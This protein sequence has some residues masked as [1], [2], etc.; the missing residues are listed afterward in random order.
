MIPLIKLTLRNPLIAWQQ[1]RRLP[2]TTGDAWS[3]VLATA[4]LS[5]L[6]SWLGAQL[7]PG[8]AEG[9]GVLAT[10]AREPMAMAGVQVASATLAA[11]L[12]A[13]VGRIFGGTGKFGDALLAIGWVEAVLITLQALQLVLTV[14]LPPLGAL[15][16]LATLLI[17][18]YLI[19]AMTMAVHGFR[20]PFFVVLGIFGTVMLT[21][22]LMSM[23]AATLG[24]I[25]GVPT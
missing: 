15:V 23:L 3:L 16:G 2:L 18:A 10:L 12:L 25:P 20:N 17:A 8:S 13:E 7:L 4:A 6:L 19:V 24:L 14:V 21:S 1:L 5:A 22:L 11:F 9:A